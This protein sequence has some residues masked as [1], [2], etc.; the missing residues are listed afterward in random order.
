MNLKVS[1]DL[2]RDLEQIAEQEFSTPK[3]VLR[4]GLKLFTIHLKKIDISSAIRG[5]K[6][7][8]EA[9]KYIISL[10]SELN[11]STDEIVF[12]CIDA[13]RSEVLGMPI[14]DRLR[15]SNRDRVYIFGNDFYEGPELKVYKKEKSINDYLT[16]L[17]EENEMKNQDKVRDFITEAKRQVKVLEQE[18]SNLEKQKQKYINTRAKMVA[19]VEVLKATEIFKLDYESRAEYKKKII[20]KEHEATEINLLLKNLEEDIKELKNKIFRARGDI[21]EMKNLFGTSPIQV[22]KLKDKYN[23][24]TTKYPVVEATW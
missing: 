18:Y 12:G 16:E 5:E 23:P 2:K 11:T 15:I 1:K 20:K 22:G 24:D 13:Y 3:G 6:G 8:E 14:K 21:E 10:A 7:I 4:K 9:E 19:E 17:V